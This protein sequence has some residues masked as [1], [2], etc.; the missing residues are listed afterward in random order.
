MFTFVTL[1]EPVCEKGNLAL[2]L[3][4]K[5]HKETVLYADKVG[6]HW[7]VQGG[8]KVYWYNWGAKA[9]LGSLNGK[10]SKFAKRTLQMEE[11]IPKF[12]HPEVK[13]Q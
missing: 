4:A 2:V 5:W 9:Q 8:P 1:V 7:H 6:G 3:K 11:E 12:L 10:G 13:R